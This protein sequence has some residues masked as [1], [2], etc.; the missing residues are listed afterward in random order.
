MKAFL[1]GLV[2]LGYADMHR[3]FLNSIGKNTIP[4][5]ALV[6]GTAMHYFLSKYLV[7]DCKMGINGTGYAG[8]ALWSTILIV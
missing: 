6:I 3:R 8:I 5:F 7:I 1:P 4:L 2:L